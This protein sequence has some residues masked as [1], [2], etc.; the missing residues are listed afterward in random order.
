MSLVPDVRM[1]LVGHK[2][3]EE[4][5]YSE[6]KRSISRE[7]GEAMALSIEAA[8]FFEICAETGENLS[9]VTLMCLHDCTFSL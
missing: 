3:C 8:G 5:E 9:A 7:E 1:V 6:E 4:G 2:Y